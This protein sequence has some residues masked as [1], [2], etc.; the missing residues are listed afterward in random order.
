MA[1]LQ[2]SRLF[3]ITYHPTLNMGKLKRGYYVQF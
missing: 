3:I 2:G 1:H